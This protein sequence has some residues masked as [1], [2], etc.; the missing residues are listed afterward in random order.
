MTQFLIVFV[1]YD[2]NPKYENYIKKIKSFFKFC[3][4]KDVVIVNTRLGEIVS[5]SSKGNTT[6][7]NNDINSEMEFSGYYYGLEWYN[8]ENSISGNSNQSFII[9]NDTILKHGKLRKIEY[10]AFNEWKLKGL[11]R[12]LTKPTI[13]GFWHT[14]I[15]LHNTEMKAGYFNSKF[16]AFYNVSLEKFGALINLNKIE[17]TILSDNTYRNNIFTSDKYS[18]FLKQWLNGKGGWYKSE[19]IN[20]RNKKLFE[21]KAKS[22]IHEHYLSKYS[23]ELSIMHNCMIKNSIFAKLIMFFTG[24]KY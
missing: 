12:R 17:V 8:K 13:C 18:L 21:A 3:S 15:F 14:S 19:K 7:T 22:I 5:L 2:Q 11:F 20:E 9:L 23:K 10:I 6:F 24:F 4:I 16:L 1:C